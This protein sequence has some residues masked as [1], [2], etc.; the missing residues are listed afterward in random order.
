MIDENNT[1]K[2][3]SKIFAIETVKTYRY[4]TETKKEFILSKQF[5]RSGTS[6]GANLAESECARSEKDFLNKLYLALKECNETIYWLELMY[7]TKY[8]EKEQYHSLLEQCS[9]IKRILNAST[10]TIKSKINNM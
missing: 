2:Y 9:E 1:A 3:K 4:L 10:K 8:L 7:E 5:L 6:I